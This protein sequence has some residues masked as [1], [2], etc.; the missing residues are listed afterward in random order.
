MIMARLGK[1]LLLLAFIIY[2]LWL[3]SAIAKSESGGQQLLLV[4]L[5][6]LIGASWVVFHSVRRRWW[7][8]LGLAISALLAYLVLGE[9]E[10]IGLIAVNGITHASLNLFL[11]WFFGH[12]LFG[13]REPLISRI[14]R[15]V[16]GQLYPE[17]VSYT[18][19]VT[20]A[21]S[22]YFAMQVVVSA[23]LY[24]L[25]PI[26]AWS[27]FINVLNL[28]LLALMFIGEHIYRGIAHPDHPRASILRSIEAYSKDLATQ[29]NSNRS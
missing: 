24:F 26:T 13:G 18:R 29:R 11:L 14:S 5:P 25:A 7:P 21:W 19:Y 9:H 4:L 2:P 20:L 3:H 17:V 15:L 6:L 10:R 12:T 27:F 1:V 16:Q 22:I 8:L 28:P 23:L